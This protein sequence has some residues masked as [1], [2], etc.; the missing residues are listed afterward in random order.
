MPKQIDNAVLEMAL[1]GY[2]A[3]RDEVV[4]KIADIERL[5]GVR[6]KVAPAPKAAAKTPAAAAKP[7]RKLSAAGKKAIRAALK[8]R[9]AEFHANA[10]S[11]K[12]AKKSAPKAKRKLSP[13]VKARLVANLAKAR[14]A[15][16][17]KRAQEAGA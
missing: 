11:A 12:P 15:K 13:A 9:W 10:D 3:K 4:Q 7:K 14:A 16:A 2:S 5:L 17:K 6:R 1:V 8:K